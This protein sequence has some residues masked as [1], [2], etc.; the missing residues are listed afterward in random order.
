MLL[1]MSADERTGKRTHHPESLEPIER[2]DIEKFRHLSYELLRYSNRGLLRGDFLP[3]VSET[4][5]EHSGCD[6]AEI[7]VKEGPDKH[8]RCSVTRSKKMP[9][10]FILVPCPLG[11]ETDSQPR[12]PDKLSMERLCAD[13]IK[14]RIDR[15]RHF[16]TE[17]GSVWSGDA[18]GAKD[19]EES[20]EA[21]H[22]V[23]K[24]SIPS[25]YQSIAVIPIWL[26]EEC[27][28]LLQLKSRKKGFFS[29]Q[30]IDFYEEISLVLGVA[31]SHQYT[32][33]ELRERIKEITC[34]YGIA[35]V[36]AQPGASFAEII[37]GIADLLPPAWLYPEITCAQI[38]LNGQSYKTKGFSESPYRQVSDVVVNKEKVGFVEV[39]YL[40]K[41]LTLDE[42]PFLIE[43][44]SLIDS[45][46][47]EVSIFYERTKAE[48]DKALL[49]EQLR[50]ADRL[51]TIGQLAA[52]VAHELNEPLGNILGFAQLAKKS[53]ALSDQVVKD[54][55]NIETASL[56][57]REIIKKLMT[58]ARQ[59]PPRK[60][61]VNLNDV[62]TEGIYFFEARCVKAGIQLVLR[63]ADDMPRITADPGQIN[64]VLVNLVVNAIQA[65]PQGGMLTVETRVRGDSV[66][67][68]VEDTGAG[69][70]EE[71][72]DQIF[73]PFFTTK[74]INEGTGLGL[75]VVHGI[76]T[77]HGGRIA[78]ETEIG[79]GTRFSIYLPLTYPERLEE[80]G[81]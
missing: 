11:E 51:A 34:L 78:V 7:W 36:M 13:I 48:A 61:P 14:G 58:F 63:L 15:S 62:V 33:I 3:K 39:V 40:E 69:M 10:G 80:R 68:S 50:H 1:I 35:R 46:A 49:Q 30:D 38:V 19:L 56:N 73:L 57:A 64:Q 23:G 18:V 52:G 81:K 41:K 28:G 45:V 67:L 5:M 20:E 4:I 43:E 8:F 12:V 47:R 2:D 27:I 17:R 74:D 25:P 59:L 32:Q 75:A 29:P 21:L 72:K 70:T 44:R 77:S 37:Q 31:L 65:M 79:V 6:A 9:H 66:C 71:L 24:M 55:Q 76:V 42:G 16:V 60:A 26:E 22:Q 54:L 53:P